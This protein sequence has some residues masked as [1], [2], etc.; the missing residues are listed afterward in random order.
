MT[1]ERDLT[2]RIGRPRIKQMARPA[3]GQ[4]LYEER[5]R[6]GWSLDKAEQEANSLGLRLKRATIYAVEEG[7]SSV[8]RR[9][10]VEA[11][12]MLYAIPRDELAILAYHP[13]DESEGEV[14]GRTPGALASGKAIKQPS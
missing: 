4:R 5:D 1:F 12:S 11:F 7:I 3:L 9:E 10:H 6:R 2:R 13:A 8:P 14:N